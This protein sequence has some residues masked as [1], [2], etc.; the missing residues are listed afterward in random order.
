MGRHLGNFG[1]VRPERSD[2]F[3]YF[4]EVDVRVHPDLTDL[5]LTDFMIR[6]ETIDENSAAAMTA[7]REFFTLLVHP[8][9]FARFWA[10]ALRNRQM[11]S[12]LL[13]TV[14]AIVEGMSSRP[15]VRRSASSAGRRKTGRK[16]K[17]DS[18]S[19][20]IRRLEQ[21]GRPDL[22]LVATQARAA[23]RAG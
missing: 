1:T 14:Y 16:S 12:D 22:A 19:R 13:G 8:D 4:D 5:F 18:S 3:N 23:Q 15:T 17:D 6:A 9:D 21:A 20:V 11:V 7:T 10:A 2:T